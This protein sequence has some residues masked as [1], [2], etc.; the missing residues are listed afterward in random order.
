MIA[1][2]TQGIDTKE[3]AVPAMEGTEVERFEVED[4]EL[5]QQNDLMNTDHNFGQIA[6]LFAASS[7][8][9]A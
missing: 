1:K 2:T 7:I 6:I 3:L 9:A 4:L 5:L 8:Y